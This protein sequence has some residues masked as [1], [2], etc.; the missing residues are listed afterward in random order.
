MTQ[1]SNKKPTG[2]QVFCFVLVQLFMV[3][4]AKRPCSFCGPGAGW[5]ADA[6]SVAQKLAIPYASI[7]KR[8]GLLGTAS[9][10]LCPN[11]SGYPGS[12]HACWT[13]F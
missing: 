4:T 11:S 1:A 7:E 2:A 10:F 5:E 8:P 13:V 6:V 3:T 12:E 9:P